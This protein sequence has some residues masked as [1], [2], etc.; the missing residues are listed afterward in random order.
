MGTD[1]W[2]GTTRPDNAQGMWSSSL[3]PL[4]A[5]TPLPTHPAP[6]QNLL[7]LSAH[8]SSELIIT[9][10]KRASEAAWHSVPNG[11][12]S[13]APTPARLPLPHTR[14]AEVHPGLCALPRLLLPAGGFLPQLPPLSFQ[15]QVECQLS[16]DALSFESAHPGC[17]F[18]RG[19]AN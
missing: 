14:T 5:W 17:S 9:H 1:P 16:Q 10:H 12:L 7:S 13:S 8:D 11:N 19:R 4:S 3:T 18:S 15:S 2:A 6:S